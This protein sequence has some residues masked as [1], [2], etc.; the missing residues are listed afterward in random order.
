M[1]LII[2]QPGVSEPLLIP[3]I[4]PVTKMMPGRKLS[5]CGYT[6]CGM[7]MVSFAW[8]QTTEQDLVSRIGLTE[9]IEV[10]FL[11]HS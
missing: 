1:R 3:Y 4:D 9:Y 2:V 11:A 7:H 10:F 8:R 6:V 5:D